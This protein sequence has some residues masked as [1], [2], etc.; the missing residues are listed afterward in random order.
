VSFHVPSQQ[1]RDFSTIRAAG[2]TGGNKKQ[3]QHSRLASHGPSLNA[4][5][6][7]NNLNL[8]VTQKQALHMQQQKLMKQNVNNFHI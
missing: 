4:M 3:G 5:L 6:N 2:G 8:S 1:Q 7:Q